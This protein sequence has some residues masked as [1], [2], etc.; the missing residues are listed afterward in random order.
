MKSE[1]AKKFTDYYRKKNVTRTYDNQREATSYRRKKRAL[2]L[3]HFLDLIEKREG[4][5]VLEL[6]C[7][8]GF[9][10]RY[11]GKVTAIDT[12]QGMLEVT[13]K[14]NPQATCIA[15][16]MFELPFKNNS[17]D[18]VVTMRVWNHLDNKDLTKA[19]LESKRVLKNEGHLIF[20]VEDKSSLRRIASKIYKLFFRPTGYTIYQHSLNETRAILK[21]QGFEIEKV[22]F[23]NHKVG[24]QIILRARAVDK[25]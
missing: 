16:D 20:D 25:K 12:S 1:D 19:I 6:G 21:K 2:E 3:R 4:E 7:S 5:K 18:K 15:T 24:R 10:T 11:L 8:S 17:F 9:L 23:L 14:K 13:R 22:R